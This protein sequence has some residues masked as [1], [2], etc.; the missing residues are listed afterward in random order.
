[1]QF[2]SGEERY[3]CL[4][5]VRRDQNV[6]E[7]QISE[8]TSQTYSNIICHDIYFSNRNWLTQGRLDSNNIMSPCPISG[9]F[10]GL[11][12]DDPELCAKL[13]SECKTGHQDIMFYQISAC[14]F[15]EVYEGE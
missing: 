12:P 5:I 8:K 7:F 13:T 9:E 14:E 11:I 6:F 10:T 3:Q 4:K 2:S 15:N 1:L